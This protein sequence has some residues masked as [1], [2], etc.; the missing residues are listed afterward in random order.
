MSPGPDA[1]V[2]LLPRSLNIIFNSIEERIYHHMNIKPQRCR[3]FIRLT[4]DQES[5]EATNKRNLF[6]LLKE[7]TGGRE[8]VSQLASH[9]R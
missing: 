3:E 2:G 7:V 6:R 4:K 8:G 9:H 5:E 1:N